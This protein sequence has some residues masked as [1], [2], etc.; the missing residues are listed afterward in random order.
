ME[1]LS[2][3]IKSHHYRVNIQI[4]GVSIFTWCMSV[5][6]T[7]CDISSPLVFGH[8]LFQCGTLQMMWVHSL[9]FEN[10]RMQ[11]CRRLQTGF[12]LDISFFKNEETDALK[13]YALTTV[14]RL[15]SES[16][17]QVFWL[18]SMSVL[19]VLQLAAI[20]VLCGEGAIP[21]VLFEFICYLAPTAVGQT[22]PYSVEEQTG[23]LCK[24]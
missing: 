5:P 14:T 21:Q 8:P 4:C 17:S 24:S 18:S 6:E 13:K 19:S 10:P 22:I 2:A 15:V 20:L 23:W 16:I 3:E 7:W 9:T 1:A 12:A 11:N